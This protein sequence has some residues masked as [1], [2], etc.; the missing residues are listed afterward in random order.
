MDLFDLLFHLLPAVVRH[1]DFG[2]IL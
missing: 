1:S 2:I